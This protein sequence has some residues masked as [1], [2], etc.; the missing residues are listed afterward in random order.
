[1][2]ALTGACIEADDIT[3][4]EVAVRAK[5]I[6]DG[7]ITRL[8]ESRFS[9]HLGVVGAVATNSATSALIL[10]L[11]ALDA[12]SGDEV[13]LPSYTCVA[14]LNA[15]RQVGATP[16]LVDNSYDVGRTGAGAPLPLRAT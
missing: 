13:I 5:A 12:G 4:M 1:M 2:I 16:C 3:S 15:I 9:E 7:E 14:I 10:A 11:A 8:F 6:S